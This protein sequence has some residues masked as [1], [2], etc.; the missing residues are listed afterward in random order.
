VLIDLEDSFYLG[1]VGAV[2][3]PGDPGVPLGF[4]EEEAVCSCVRNN[5]AACGSVWVAEEGLRVGLA[6]VGYDYG[7][8]LDLCEAKQ[9]VKVAVQ[10]LLSLAEVLSTDVFSSEMRDE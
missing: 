8:V 3:Y 2:D 1:E 9:F 4:S 5:V 10:L 6:L 7:K